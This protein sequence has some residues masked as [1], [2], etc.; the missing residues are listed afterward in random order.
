MDGSSAWT[1]ASAANRPPSAV[2]SV[3][4]ELDCATGAVS[5]PSSHLECGLLPVPAGQVRI[6]FLPGHGPG[7]DGVTDPDTLDVFLPPF[8]EGGPRVR[9]GETADDER[10]VLTGHPC[11]GG[12]LAGFRD[13][14]LNDTESPGH[15]E[16]VVIS[17][18][19]HG[20][21]SFATSVRSATFFAIAVRDAMSAS[22]AGGRGAFE[23]H[24][25]RT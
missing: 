17:D 15:L 25:R 2:M 12:V 1:S 3:F 8:E 24:A 16:Q 18:D 5:V 9:V 11:C 13:S 14:G 21:I 23:V 10:H 22:V 20:A 4:S 7:A 6:D 19:V